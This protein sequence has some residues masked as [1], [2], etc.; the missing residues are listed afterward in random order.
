MYRRRKLLWMPRETRFRLVHK[1]GLKK[2]RD[3][4]SRVKLVWG[5]HAVKTL[6]SRR[7]SA[8]PLEAARRALS[9]FLKKME[10]LWIRAIP[11]IPVTAKPTQ[12]RMGKGKGDVDYWT[13]NVTAGTVLFEVGAIDP[14]KV[15]KM[16]RTLQTR[17]GLASIALH[18]ASF[19]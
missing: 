13:Y 11:N 14:V 12:I 18:R 19:V 7:L 10:K 16:F 17:L 4:S 15:W 2:V 1:L 8:K 5:E 3:T 9:R 6:N